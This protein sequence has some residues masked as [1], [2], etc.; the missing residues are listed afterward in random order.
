MH[1]VYNFLKC[2]IDLLAENEG[3]HMWL[4]KL[5]YGRYFFDFWH[6]PA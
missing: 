3:R 1:E 5:H 4:N 6:I 2:I